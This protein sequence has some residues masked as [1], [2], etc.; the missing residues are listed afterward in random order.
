M[1]QTY[2]TPSG[3]KTI[4]PPWGEWRRF[5][6]ELP[7]VGTV[8]DIDC[9]GVIREGVGPLQVVRQ[10]TVNDCIYAE[11][12]SEVGWF[13]IDADN[14]VGAAVKGNYLWKRSN[15]SKI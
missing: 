7:V 12:D 3:Y 14:A 6:D 13:I 9:E 1:N 10:V 15:E 5:N 8:I 11:R 4:D 2:W